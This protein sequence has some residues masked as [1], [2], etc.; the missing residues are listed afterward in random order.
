L[1]QD[2]GLGKACHCG[3]VAGCLLAPKAPLDNARNS[4]GTQVEYD[5]RREKIRYAE[6]LQDTCGREEKEEERVGVRKI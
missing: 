2:L 5:H 3:Y 4:I 1:Q 6:A